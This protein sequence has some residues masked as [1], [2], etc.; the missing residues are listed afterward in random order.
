MNLTNN[1]DPLFVCECTALNKLVMGLVEPCECCQ[2]KWL[3]SSCKQ[4]IV[5]IPNVLIKS[6]LSGPQGI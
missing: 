2:T 4:V 3:T 1:H 5:I 6:E